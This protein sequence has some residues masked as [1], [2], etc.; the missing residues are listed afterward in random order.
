[1]TFRTD[2]IRKLFNSGVTYREALTGGIKLKPL[3]C[4]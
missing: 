2:L 4:K 3:K 1:V